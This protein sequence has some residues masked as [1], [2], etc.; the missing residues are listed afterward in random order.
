MTALFVV[1][2]ALALL[3]LVRRALRPHQPEHRFQID[4][5]YRGIRPGRTPVVLRA[6]CEHPSC[7][8][9]LVVWEEEEAKARRAYAHFHRSAR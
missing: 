9:D 6:R 7:R 2:A 4:W 3:W 8:F 1:L 5:D